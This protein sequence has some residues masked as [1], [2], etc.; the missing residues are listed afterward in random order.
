CAPPSLL[1]PRAAPRYAPRWLHRRARRTGVVARHR[2]CPP[3]RS[4]MG[5]SCLRAWA[6]APT[7]EGGN[8]GDGATAGSAWRR[9]VTTPRIF[10]PEYYARMRELETSGWWNAAMRD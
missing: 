10:T 2:T 6:P 3:Q 7:S 8:A 4:S 9:G 5:G 1:G